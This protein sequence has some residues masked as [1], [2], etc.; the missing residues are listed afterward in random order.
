M[1][2]NAVILYG[3]PHKNGHTKKA[4]DSVLNE[5]NDFYNFEFVDA[6]N[7]NIQ[8]CNDC[9][10]CEKNN[11]CAFADF[12][13]IDELLRKCE[14]LIIATPVYNLSF[15]APL[16]A[17]IDRTQL[18][19]NMKTKLKINPFKREKRVI[20]VITYGSKDSSCEE[21]ILKQLK[22]FFILINARLSKA[23]FIGNTDKI[24]R[25]AD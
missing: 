18:Y 17:I 25:R 19:F 7:E 22:L 2:K 4:L 6:F 10:F 21:I 24:E 20:L 11:K 23:I 12:S 14:L 13:H 1:K 9:G 5:L 15:P 16:K 8:P 3:S